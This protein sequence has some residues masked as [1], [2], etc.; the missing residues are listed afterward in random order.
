MQEEIVKIVKVKEVK[1][2][3]KKRVTKKKVVSKDVATQTPKPVR[4]VL[5]PILSTELDMRVKYLHKRL[6]HCN[7]DDKKQSYLN[8][9]DKLHNREVIVI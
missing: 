1:K 6:Y 5:K 2:P 4:P 7:D 8:Q 3:R 9:L